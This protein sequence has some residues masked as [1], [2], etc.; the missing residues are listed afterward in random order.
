MNKELS[1]LLVVIGITLSCRSNIEKPYILKFTIPEVANSQIREPI[2]SKKYRADFISEVFPIF[3]GKFR[4]ANKIDISPDK[5]DTAMS[6][7][8]VGNYSRSRIGDSI[9]INGFEL[10]VDYDQVVKFRQYDSIVYEYYPVYF[11]NSTKSDKMFLG[12]DDYIFGIQEAL[13][14]EKWK[15]WRPI[16]SRGFDFC[17]NGRWGLIVHPN[18][19]VV[20]LM[21]K[22]EGDFQTAMRVRFELGDNIYVS[23]PFEGIIQES[24][25]RIQDSSYLEKQLRETNGSAASWLFYGAVPR[26]EEWA[27]KAF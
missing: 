21:R 17:G 9:D 11:V 16:E 7:D 22:Y 4:F 19:F 26:Q 15:S 20:I 6:K 5:R 2:P 3:A 1:I 12:K 23:K 24:Q 10:I 18:E 14:N 27:V 13:D 8:F 25:F